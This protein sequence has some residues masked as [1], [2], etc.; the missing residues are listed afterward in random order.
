MKFAE[1]VVEIETTAIHDLPK[2]KDGSTPVIV[3]FLSTDKKT[4]IIRKRKML[5][6]SAVFLNDHLT[7]QNNELFAEARRL[8]K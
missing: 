3:Q 7:Q 1:S 4:E 5:K 8:K 2:R 6:G